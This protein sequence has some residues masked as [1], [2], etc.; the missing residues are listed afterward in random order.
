MLADIN[1]IKPIREEPEQFSEVR[2]R[3]DRRKAKKV[4]PRNEASRAKNHGSKED[5]KGQGLSRYA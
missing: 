3:E 1:L 4:L 2:R 5:G